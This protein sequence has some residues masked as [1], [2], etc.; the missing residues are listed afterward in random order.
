MKQGIIIAGKTEDI[1]NYIH[2][3]KKLGV[4]AE[5]CFECD[6]EGITDYQ[7]L[8]LPGGGDFA[9]RL[10]HEENHGS[11]LDSVD[12]TL[13]MVQWRL[14]EAYIR[15]KKPV[16]GICKGM[17]LINLYYGGTL[18]QNLKTAYSH[19]WKEEDQEHMTIAVQGSFLESLYG[20][21]FPVNSAHHQ[22]VNQLGHDLEAVQ[23][24]EDRVIEAIRHKTQPVYG[25]QWHPERMK[26]GNRLLEFW[27]RLF[28]KNA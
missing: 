15:Q 3:F 18:V 11:R 27:I 13:D 9:L 2:A 21:R 16:L 20:I 12:E 10:L 1:G 14:L 8:V 4:D 6:W 22:G 5:G 24:A 28:P 23:F 19:E 7:G 25:V 26:H 17:Q